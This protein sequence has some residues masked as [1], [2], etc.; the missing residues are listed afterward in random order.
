MLWLTV[1]IH[2]EEKDVTTITL[3]SEVCSLSLTD[4]L[5]A[6]ELKVNNNTTNGDDM[7]LEDCKL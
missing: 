1:R 2:Q 4:D 6:F 5:D 7:D 3:V